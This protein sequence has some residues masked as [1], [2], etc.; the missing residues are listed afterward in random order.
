[1]PPAY[2]AQLAL[3]RSLLAADLPGPE[4]SAALLF[5]EAPRLIALPAAVMDEALVQLTKA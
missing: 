5:T 3:Y 4:V 2:V 1:M